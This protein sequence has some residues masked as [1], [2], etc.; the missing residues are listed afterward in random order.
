MGAVDRSSRVVR[1]T[2]PQPPLLQSRSGVVADINRAE[3]KVGPRQG[4][5]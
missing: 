3:V 5:S 4:K 2:G 1:S